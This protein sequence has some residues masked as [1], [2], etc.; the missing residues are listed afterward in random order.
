MSNAV[1][2]AVNA[3]PANVALKKIVVRKAGPVRLTA[4]AHPMYGS[5]GN[6][7]FL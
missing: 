1:N 6:P 3:A 5:C 4:A 7:K 2:E